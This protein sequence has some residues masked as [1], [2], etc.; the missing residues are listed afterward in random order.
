MAAIVGTSDAIE[1]ATNSTRRY[2][3]PKNQSTV[4]KEITA[5]S[6]GDTTLTLWMPSRNC[7]DLFP[8]RVFFIHRQI[9]PE[10]FHMGCEKLKI[11]PSVAE[12]ENR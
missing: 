5:N 6:D 10:G 1:A 12:V 8:S 9:Y 4:L 3:M 2:K 11:V 7:F